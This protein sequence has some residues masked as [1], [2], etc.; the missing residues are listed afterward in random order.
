[1]QLHDLGVGLDSDF[2]WFNLT[3]KG[4]TT[5]AVE[6][7]PARPWLGRR[8]FRHAIAH[9]IDRQ[10]FVDTVLLGA[11]APV[12]GPITP[13]TAS[14]SRPTCRPIPTIRPR[15]ARCSTKSG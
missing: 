3:P 9:A 2:L 8:E 14:G 11:G 7:A 4:P 10:Q 1:M 6:G 13:G 5:T 12:Y 15:R